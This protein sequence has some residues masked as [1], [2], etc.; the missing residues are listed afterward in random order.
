MIAEKFYKPV[1][2]LY[3]LASNVTNTH[4][5]YSLLLPRIAQRK[6]VSSVYLN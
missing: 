3:F 4:R 1:M 2:K 6:G 5:I